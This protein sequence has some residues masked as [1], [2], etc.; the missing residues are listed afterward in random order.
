[1]PEPETQKKQGFDLES[2][3]PLIML[4]AP[5]LEAT[6]PGS[7]MGLLSGIGNFQ[8]QRAIRRRQ[9]SQ[10]LLGLLSEAD[11]ENLGLATEALI[12]QGY[13]PQTVKAMAKAS[14]AFVDPARKTNAILGKITKGMLG[15]QE[16]E[17]PFGELQRLQAQERLDVQREGR[18]ATTEERRF[19]RQEVTEEKRFERGQGAQIAGEARQLL[20]SILLNPSAS[21]QSRVQA[22]QLFNQLTPEN[23]AQILAQAQTMVGQVGEAG[24]GR[25]QQERGLAFRQRRLAELEKLAESAVPGNIGRIRA[26]AKEQGLDPSPYIQQLARNIRM[27]GLQEQQVR[28]QIA[29]A[30]RSNRGGGE[31]SLNDIKVAILAGKIDP[32]KLSPVARQILGLDPEKPLKKPPT[33]MQ[34]HEMILKIDRRRKQI[35]ALGQNQQVPIDKRDKYQQEYDKLSDEREELVKLI[36]P[37]G[38]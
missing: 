17:L 24:A 28:A 5:I 9:E 6:S 10:A 32:A 27:G 7:G 23:A 29:A 34:V 16:V 12:A 14:R 22:K 36:G 37:A 11:D 26:I 33:R 19:E 21:P 38:R 4:A 13:D 2:I 1:M 30:D 15:G 25:E 18:Q 3:L 35:E 8:Q 31:I 20:T